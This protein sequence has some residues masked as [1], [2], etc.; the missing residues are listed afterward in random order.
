VSPRTV[1]GDL[2]QLQAGGWLANLESGK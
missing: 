2:V 1:H